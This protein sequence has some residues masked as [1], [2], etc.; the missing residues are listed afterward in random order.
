[1]PVQPTIDLINSNETAIT[2]EWPRPSLTDSLPIFRYMLHSDMGI[3]GSDTVVFETQNLN[4]V[5]ATH[6]GL[7]PGLIYS[8]WL[9]IENFNGNSTDLTF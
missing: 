5:S 7:T 8:Y 6:K 3:P 9:K 4:I 2:L 1:M